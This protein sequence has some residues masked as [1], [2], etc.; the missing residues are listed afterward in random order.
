MPY[1][2]ADEIPNI[3]LCLWRYYRRKIFTHAAQG[4][5]RDIA[6]KMMVESRS[7]WWRVAEPF[8]LRK[9]AGLGNGR[10]SPTIQSRGYKLSILSEPSSFQ[11]EYVR[12]AMQ[13]AT[14][15]PAVISPL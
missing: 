12:R 11:H 15:P 10:R 5:L 9:I 8:S 13:S 14:V 3:I 7:P 2:S 1:A 6:H 4:L